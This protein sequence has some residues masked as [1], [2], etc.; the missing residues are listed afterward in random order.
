MVII[1]EIWYIVYASYRTYPMEIVTLKSS[2][3]YLHFSL[4]DV[5]DCIS[6]LSHYNKES[7]FDDS[8]LHVLKVWHDQY[9]IV[10]SLYVQ[11]DFSINSKYAKELIDNGSWLKFGYHGSGRYKLD[12]WKFYK[13]IK[14]SVKT[15]IIID[16]CPRLDYFH[17]NYMTCII[18][19]KFGC[20]GF[21][22]C[23]DWSYNA[24]NRGSNYYL[25]PIQTQ[26]LD[27][28]SRL[29]DTDNNLLFIKPDFRL[30][31][32][33]QR[34]KNV[35]GCLKYYSNHPIQADELI[36]F[37][38]EWAFQNYTSQA[39]SIFTWANKEGYKFDFPMNN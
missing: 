13:Q 21:L 5:H 8:T 31:Q 22:G 10:V 20:I 19:Q 27:E 32:I 16:K 28:N 14:D 25:S 37:S 30:E 1:I 7:I 38:H 23:D 34:W 33:A 24:D 29:L 39:D 6:R 3:K 18:L 11:G 4:D 12:A 35:R 36:I 15:D 2:N 26:I 9:G 17:A